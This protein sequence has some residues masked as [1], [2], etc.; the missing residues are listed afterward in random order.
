MYHG[1]HVFHVVVVVVVGQGKLVMFKLQN[2]TWVYL[3]IRVGTYQ[4]FI[5]VYFLSW[6]QCLFTAQHGR[7]RLYSSALHFSFAGEQRRRGS[8]VCV[9][10]HQLLHRQLPPGCTRRRLWAAQPGLQRHMCPHDFPLTGPSS[11][12]YC[13]AWVSSS[14]TCVQREGVTLN[15]H[16]TSA[17][18]DL[19][20]W[21]MIENISMYLV[22]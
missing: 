13:Q 22:K 16:A 8:E 20:A 14:V 18:R 2:S 4:T 3:R 5:F 10:Q 17:E 15:Q 21:S 9:P 7:C 11:S 1:I 12:Q 6:N 19:L